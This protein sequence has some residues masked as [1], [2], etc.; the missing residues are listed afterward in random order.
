[1]GAGELGYQRGDGV[2]IDRLAPS[3]REYVAVFDPPPGVARLESFGGL[4]GLV[5][6]E[7]GD[8][9]VIDGDDAGPAA[10][11]RAANTLTCDDGC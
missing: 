3:G 10:L 9:F 4:V 11:G 5:L 1:V 6:A 2:G 7:D 8:R